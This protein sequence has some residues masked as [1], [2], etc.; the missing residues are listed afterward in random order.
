MLVN[1]ST[2]MERDMFMLEE[3]MEML[4]QHLYV[5]VWV[6]LTHDRVDDEKHT[7]NHDRTIRRLHALQHAPPIPNHS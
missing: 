2:P 4:R 7:S 6:S 1:D 5:M 3:L